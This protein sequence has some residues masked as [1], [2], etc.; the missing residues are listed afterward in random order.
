M[1]GIAV[2]ARRVLKIQAGAE[3]N[4][5][6]IFSAKISITTKDS[7]AYEQK[8]RR[9]TIS[10]C[11]Y[12]CCNP[13]I[14]NGLQAKPSWPPAGPGATKANTQQSEA[15]SWKLEAQCRPSAARCVSATTLKLA[16]WSASE[17][18]PIQTV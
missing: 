5:T 1:K 7:T 17:L 15:S 12:G 2:F 13:R 11:Q 18:P 14:H 9:H 6:R 8:S 3:P 4:K 16:S 10:V